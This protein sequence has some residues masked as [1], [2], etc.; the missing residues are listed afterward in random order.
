MQLS[1]LVHPDKAPDDAR[2]AD[3][4]QEVRKAYEQLQDAARRSIVVAHIDNVLKSVR[5]ERRKRIK[6]GTP[7][8]S[9]P[10]LDEELARETRKLFA[11]MEQRR[12]T[13]EARLK[14]EAAREVQKQMDE[15]ESSREEFKVEAAWAE[16]REARKESWQSF[17]EAAARKKRRLE[18]GGE[19][20]ADGAAA[21]AGTGLSAAEVA[22]FGASAAVQSR[23]GLAGAAD[24]YK[25]KW[26]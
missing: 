11:E 21:S 17:N 18:A 3:A 14:A 19:D 16:G 20:N 22:R 1:A 25:R 23:G 6:A 10:P 9:L 26:R 15:V 8:A 5:R 4:F 2:A 12:R 24:E 7:E 13:A